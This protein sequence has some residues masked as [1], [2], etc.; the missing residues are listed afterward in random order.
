MKGNP[1]VIKVL[2]EVL[3]KELTGINQYF[4]HAKMCKNWGYAVLGEHA[5]NESI[6]EMKHADQIVER[7]LFLEGTPNVQAY[8]KIQVGSN[9]KQ[10][11]ENDLGLEQAALTVLRPGIK[12]CLDAHDDATRELLEHIVVDEEHHIDWIETQFHQIKEVG[13]E[14]YLAQ[15]IFKKS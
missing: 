1:E 10:Q 9:V 7:I 4:I 8:D 3:R 15:Q 13:Y 12:T 6:D 2:N 14:N 5:W 11:L